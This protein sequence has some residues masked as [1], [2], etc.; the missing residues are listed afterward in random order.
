VQAQLAPTSTLIIDQTVNNVDYMVN[1]ASM[2]VPPRV[3][4]ALTTLVG[5]YVLLTITM[6]AVLAVLSGIAQQ[7]ATQEAWVHA[8]IV[9]V[10]AVVLPLRLR[11]AR[12]GSPGALRAVGIIAVVLMMVNVV[13]ALIPGLLPAWMRIEMLVIALVLLGAILVVVKTRMVR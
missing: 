12:A 10:F 5:S 11:A 8:V 9:A 7:F 2:T 6:L 3:G 13:E 4:R 1:N